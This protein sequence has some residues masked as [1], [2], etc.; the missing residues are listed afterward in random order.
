MIPSIKTTAIIDI[1]RFYLNLQKS[2]IERSH[3]FKIKICHVSVK[4][5]R[6]LR[7]TQSTS[8]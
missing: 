3:L 1:G 6:S 7:G 5:L 2:H 8:T 4:T